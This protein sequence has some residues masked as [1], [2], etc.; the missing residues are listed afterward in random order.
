[1]TGED[2]TAL[3]RRIVQIALPQD[4]ETLAGIVAVAIAQIEGPDLS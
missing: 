4:G 1:M 2:V 3:R